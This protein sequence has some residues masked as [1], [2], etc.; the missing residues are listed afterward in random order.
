M[1]QKGPCTS[2]C[3]CTADFLYRTLAQ[4]DFES[5]IVVLQVVSST[6]VLSGARGG[7]NGTTDSAQKVVDGRSAA[8]DISL[9]VSPATVYNAGKAV[10]NTQWAVRS[11]QGLC[12]YRDYTIP[13]SLP[14]FS[15]EWVQS[16]VCRLSFY[17]LFVASKVALVYW[18]LV[19][20]QLDVRQLSQQ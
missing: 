7:I 20:C 19:R 15:A 9:T 17:T 2:P 4:D 16:A 12:Q 1:C 8:L 10:C 14:L 13:P 3:C 5:G 6:A 18:Q 11:G